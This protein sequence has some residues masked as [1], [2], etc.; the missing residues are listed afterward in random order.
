MALD[1]SSYEKVE[2]DPI[3]NGRYHCRIDKVEMKYTKGNADGSG[4][5]AG[6]GF[7]NVMWRVVSPEEYENRVVFQ[8]V[9]IIDKSTIKAGYDEGKA[10]KMKGNMVAFLEGIGYDLDEITSGSF[11]PNTDDFQDREALLVVGTRQSEG[12]DPQNTVRSVKTLDNA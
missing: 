6:T 12:Y 8:P 3:P 10:K 4:L 11:E 2:F 9:F 5:P 1:L 7:W